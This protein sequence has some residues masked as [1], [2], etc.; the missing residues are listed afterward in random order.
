VHSASVIQRVCGGT[1]LLWNG[2]GWRRRGYL[3]RGSVSPRWPGQWG[4][5]GSRSAAGHA[6]LNNREWVVCARPS[7]PGDH[8]SSAQ[9]SGARF[10]GRSNAGLKRW[11]LPPGFGPASQLH[12][13]N[14]FQTG[15]RYHRPR[16]IDIE[17]DGIPCGFSPST[18]SANPSKSQNHP[19]RSDLLR[20]TA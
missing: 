20:T 7:T 10:S 5:I 8:P 4:C 16:Y 6:G 14:W 17:R 2:R 3:K 1:S 19:P 13:L 12:D 18:K 11:D 9:P 15:V